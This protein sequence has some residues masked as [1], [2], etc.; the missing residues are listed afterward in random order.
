MDCLIPLHEYLKPLP[1]FLFKI[2][3]EEFS[4]QKCQIGPKILSALYC[5]LSANDTDRIF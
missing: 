1:C 2:L 5:N 4:L 3:E